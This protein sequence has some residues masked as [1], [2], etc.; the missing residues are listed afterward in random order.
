MPDAMDRVTLYPSMGPHWSTA[1]PRNEV[2]VEYLMA[3]P[4]RKNAEKMLEALQLW[5]ACGRLANSCNII[6]SIQR[7]VNEATGSDWADGIDKYRP[8]KF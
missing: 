3:T 5:L 4:A 2:G 6:E 1:Q 8:N 7:L